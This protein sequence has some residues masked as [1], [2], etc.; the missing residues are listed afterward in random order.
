MNTPMLT[1]YFDGRCAFCR[2]GMARLEGWDHHH[3]L[4]FVDIAR[5]DFDP[6]ELDTDMA[7]VN[8][9]LYARQADG[10]LLT[11]LDAIVAAYRLV[12]QGW[13]VAWTRFFLLR[14]LMSALYLLFARHR[15]FFSRLLG[16]RVPACE[17]GVCP[18]P[19]RLLER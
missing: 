3:R 12:G 7:S 17:D 11:G 15:Y 10:G 13:R 5:P 9:E 16:Y 4:A 6:A 19:V 8:R 14:R 2:A 1:L 18:S